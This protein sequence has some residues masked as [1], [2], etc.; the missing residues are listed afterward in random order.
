MVCKEKKEMYV[1]RRVR[2]VS[3]EKSV[4]GKAEEE[5]EESRLAILWEPSY[6]AGNGFELD[7]DELARREPEKEAVVIL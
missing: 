7:K 1:E 2:G 6:G 4:S 5:E 3:R